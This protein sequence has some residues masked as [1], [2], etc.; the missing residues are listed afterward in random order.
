MKKAEIT[1]VLWFQLFRALIAVF[2]IVGAITYCTK[3][4]DAY[5]E[6]FEKAEELIK[7]LQGKERNYKVSD[8][9][10]L[11]P[12]RQMGVFFRGE[13]EYNYVAQ[14]VKSCWEETVYSITGDR[15]QQTRIPSKNPETNC[16]SS[17]NTA[18]LVEKPAS[19]GIDGCFCILTGFSPDN[20]ITELPSGEQ[21]NFDGEKVSKYYKIKYDNIRCNNIDYPPA[22]FQRINVTNEVK[23]E[24]FSSSFGIIQ[25][26]KVE[27]V[28]QEVINVGGTFMTPISNEAHL[29][30]FSPRPSPD[31]DGFVVCKFENQC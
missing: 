4:T 27:N 18:Y 16:I 31:Q 24:K 5:E 2:L 21:L 17:S 22:K 3:N 7:S 25:E 20:T 30:Y 9:F 10:V 8:I 12:E 14:Y 26:L 19:C 11:E 28:T 29:F 1:V 6:N 15:R 23:V 13:Q